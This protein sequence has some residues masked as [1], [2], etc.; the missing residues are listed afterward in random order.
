MKMDKTL[1]ASGSHHQF[2]SFILP[3]VVPPDSHYR[4]LP[5]LNCS[6][7]WSYQ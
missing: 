4:P 6:M 5:C 2:S 7:P 3:G 1:A